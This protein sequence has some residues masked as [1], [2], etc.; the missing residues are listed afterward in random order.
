MKAFKEHAIKK[1]Q[2][3]FNTKFGL[4]KMSQ[5]IVGSQVLGEPLMS[6]SPIPEVNDLKESIVTNESKRIDVNV[7]NEYD[8]DSVHK[9]YKLNLVDE[10]SDDPTAEQDFAEQLKQVLEE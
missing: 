9:K 8:S 1:A 3:D 7:P 2:E 5:T 4:K 6:S 10:N